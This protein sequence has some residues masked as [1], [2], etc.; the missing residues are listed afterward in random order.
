[1]EKNRKFFLK[2][3]LLRLQIANN[4]N[5]TVYGV[6]TFSSKNKKGNA[7]EGCVIKTD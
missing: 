4:N 1:M 2:N 3:P 5:L 7:F 6:V